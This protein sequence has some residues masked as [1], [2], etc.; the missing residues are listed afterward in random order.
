MR[1]DDQY[2]QPGDKVMRVAYAGQFPGARVRPGSTINNLTD[3]GRV[4]CVE[5]CWLHPRI[6]N[7][8]LFVG[9]PPREPLAWRAACFRKVDEIK[10][11]VA[12]VKH[13]E[14]PIEP[15]IEALKS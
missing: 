7:R 13:K 3:F 6:G 8:V 9:I 2:F 15:P 5:A 10:L 4:L 14:T 1:T 11:C 12:A